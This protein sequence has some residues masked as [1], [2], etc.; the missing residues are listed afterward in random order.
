MKLS[1]VVAVLSLS[2]S[3]FGCA[4]GSDANELPTPTPAREFSAP[5][6]EP[7]MPPTLVEDTDGL[8]ATDTVYNVDTGND[9]AAFLNA[10][11][12]VKPPVNP[13]PKH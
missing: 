11:H 2:L 1:N 7:S 9:R 3:L 10:L 6:E 13:I 12:E 8:R 5:L 4:V